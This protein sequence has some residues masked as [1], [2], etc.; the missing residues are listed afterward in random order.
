M[1]IDGDL[2]PARVVQYQRHLSAGKA[3]LNVIL[4]FKRQ[5]L[6]LLCHSYSFFVNVID[7]LSFSGWV[8]I[9]TK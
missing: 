3:G 5:T 2:L 4:N 9:L 1:M 8:S 6:M 7:R